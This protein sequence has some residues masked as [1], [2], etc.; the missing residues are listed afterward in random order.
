MTSSAVFVAITSV[1]KVGA[2][3]APISVALLKLEE[4]VVM[5]PAGEHHAWKEPPAQK[6]AGG[7]FTFVGE[8]GYATLGITGS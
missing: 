5:S 1:R 4:L 3:L 8:G 6:P 7:S 2:D